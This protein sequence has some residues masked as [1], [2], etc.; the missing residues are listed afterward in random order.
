MPLTDSQV[1]YYEN[2]LD[3]LDRALQEALAENHDLRMKVAELSA[4]KAEDIK[5]TVD[6]VTSEWSVETILDMLAEAY[7]KKQAADDE[8]EGDPESDPKV[9]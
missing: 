6:Q 2:Q 8:V 5:A 3:K 1:Q 9:E 7:L 4:I